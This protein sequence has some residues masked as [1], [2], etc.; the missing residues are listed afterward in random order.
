MSDIFEEVEESIRQDRATELWKK[1]GI[2]AWIVGFAIIGTVAYFEWNKTQ[3]RKAVEANIVRFEDA[4]G[5][6]EAGDYAGAQ[7]DFK[8]LVDSGTNISP[9]A[10]HYL[11]RAYYEGNGDV[12]AAADI[13]AVNS[14][15]EGPVERMSLLKAAYLRSDTMTLAELETFLGD[16]PKESTALGVMAL[17]L[18]AAKALKEGDLERAREEFGY[19]RFAQD[20]PAGVS[21][22]AEIALSIIPVPEGVAPDT[23][24]EAGAGDAPET[25]ETAG[26]EAEQETGE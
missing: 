16:L 25:E 7:T 3:N 17:E 12:A 2:I 21:R 4:R 5:K 10:A 15:L 9:L 24:T 8:A 19:I 23:E 13:L 1:Y 22:R 26:D 14:G 6:L 20:V 18:I 11:A